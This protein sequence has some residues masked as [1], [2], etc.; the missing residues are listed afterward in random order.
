MKFSDFL[1]ENNSTDWYLVAKLDLST[2]SDSKQRDVR[3]LLDDDKELIKFMTLHHTVDPVE[4]SPNPKLKSLKY[5]EYVAQ[6]DKN[7]DVV[8]VYELLDE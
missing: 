2:I 8:Y 4:K 6:Y 1:N 7:K 5:K 3:D